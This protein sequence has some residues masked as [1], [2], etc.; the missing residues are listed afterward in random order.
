MIIPF[1]HL[2]FRPSAQEVLCHCL[3]WSAPKQL[4]FFQDVSDRIEKESFSSHVVQSL[5]RGGIAVVKGSW[6]DHITE[7][8]RQGMHVHVHVHVHVKILN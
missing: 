3:F 8:L 5:E 2:L 1:C 4:S 6:K 7:D